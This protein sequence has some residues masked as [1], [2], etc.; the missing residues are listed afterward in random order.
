MTNLITMKV[1]RN[2]RNGGHFLSCW[3]DGP[4]VWR[5]WWF[6]KMPCPWIGIHLN[7]LFILWWPAFLGEVMHFWMNLFIIFTDYKQSFCTML[8]CLQLCKLVLFTFVKHR[9]KSFSEDSTWESQFEPAHE[10]MVLITQAT[11]EG[12]G[13]HTYLYSL[14]RA[15]A[16]RTN[17]VWK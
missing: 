16:V 5:V 15:I 3:V 8:P 2:K 12:S 9:F 17:E 4:T 1:I 7:V 6:Y 10:I 14:A 11:S 13:Q